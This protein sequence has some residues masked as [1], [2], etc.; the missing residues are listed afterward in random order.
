MTDSKHRLRALTIW[1]PW[2]ALIMIGAKPWEWRRW[3]APENLIGQRMVIHAG[4]RVPKAEEMRGA[5]LEIRAG[6]SSL[7]ADLAVSVLEKHPHSFL[8]GVGLG[9]ALVGRPIG[10]AEWSRQHE[11]VR[12]DSDRIDHHAWGWPLTDIQP[13]AE[14]V[15][16]KGAQGLWNWN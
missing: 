12:Y 10:A 13:F 11:S 4:V 6:R 15:L 5:I 14:P 1:Q 8:F 3:P 9:T 16:R 7:I 2:A